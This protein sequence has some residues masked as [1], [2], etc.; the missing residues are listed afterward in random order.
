MGTTR[1]H[2]ESRIRELTDKLAPPLSEQAGAPPRRPPAYVEEASQLPPC[3]DAPPS[4]SQ[5]QAMSSGD[6]SEAMTSENQSEAS[7]SDGQTKTNPATLK[8]K[9]DVEA[10]LLELAQEDEEVVISFATCSI[11]FVLKQLTYENFHVLIYI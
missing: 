3:Y 7:T 2:I 5:S 9:L 10:E 4:Y 11:Y 1:L 8:P 6:P